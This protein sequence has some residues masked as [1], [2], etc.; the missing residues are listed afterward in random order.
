MCVSIQGQKRGI[1]MVVVSCP[2]S[3]YYYDDDHNNNKTKEKREK[4][5]CFLVSFMFSHLTHT[6]KGLW[7]WAIW[8]SLAFLSI[9]RQLLWG[10]EEEFVDCFILLCVFL[11]GRCSSV[12]ETIS[13]LFSFSQRL[14]L[15]LSSPDVSRLFLFLL[16]PSSTFIWCTQNK[17]PW[18]AGGHRY[19]SR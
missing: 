2:S 7:W 11:P 1:N 14:S 3:I 6:Q 9:I 19:W 12:N 10:E 16:G 13:P 15:S 17:A 4:D 18:S 5:W 8:G